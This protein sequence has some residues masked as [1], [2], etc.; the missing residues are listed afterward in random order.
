MESIR[1]NSGQLLR[2]VNREE[3][4]KNRGH[5]KIFFGYAADVGKTYAM[6]KAAHGAKRRGV[7]VV[8]GYVE[9]H[10]RPQTAALLHGLE[11]VPPLMVSENGIA[12]REFNLDAAIARRPALVLVDIEPQE[13]LERLSGG[14][15]YKEKQ[16]KRAAENFFTIKN[17]TA[18]R[19]IVIG[20]STAARRAFFGKPAMTERLIAQ[21]PNLDIHIIPDSTSEMAYRAKRL[22]KKAGITFSPGDA[23]KSLCMLMLTTG[24]SF[25]F[26]KIGLSEA[27][28]IMI[29]ILGVLITSV[30]TGHQIYSLVASFISVLVFNFFFTEPRFSLSAYEKDYPVT[31]IVM[32]FSAFLT[33]SLAVKL[34]NQARQSAGAA[35]RTKIL[36][37]TN[38]LLEQVQD[39]EEIIDVTAGQLMKLLNRDMTV[40]PA[41]KGK[42]LPPRIFSVTEEGRGRYVTENERA[43]AEWVLK[44]NKHAGATTD[45][46]SGAECLYLSIRMNEHV[47]G[48]IGI[49]AG[50][51]AGCLREQYP[52]VHTGR[53]RAG[54]GE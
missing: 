25:L 50:A 53:M 17:L 31:F 18:L 36:Y 26:W 27:N 22:K 19:E 46:L 8:A 34:K 30:I 43:V 6:L 13:L 54:A 23:L 3:Y 35:Y 41:E 29:Y 40:Y 9:P 45:T 11:Q 2:A 49:A 52:V 48:V 24:M 32:F 47:Y 51:A 20:R 38:Q 28:I 21:A 44:N 10:A 15:I 7:D 12:L 42:L 33:S 5:L 14:N 4:E 37:D 39:R 16:A 1:V